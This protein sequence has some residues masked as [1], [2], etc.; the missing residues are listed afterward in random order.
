MS[1]QSIGEGQSPRSGLDAVP[2][3]VPP[4]V[5]TLEGVLSAA[6]DTLEIHMRKAHFHETRVGYDSKGE[7]RFAR[8]LGPVNARL[9]ANVSM[10]ELRSLG[11]DFWYT[12]TFGLFKF[13]DGPVEMPHPTLSAAAIAV[14]LDKE[15]GACI[16]RLGFIRPTGFVPTTLKLIAVTRDG[17]QWGYR[18][19]DLPI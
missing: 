14:A 10:A 6:L 11:V 1:I 12:V 7:I 8:D 9:P 18:T 2:P 16:G 13:T 5:M 19:N 15:G 17:P 3:H 4:S